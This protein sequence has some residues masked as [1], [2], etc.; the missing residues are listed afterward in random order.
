MI[1]N[2]FVLCNLPGFANNTAAR[3]GGVA[4]GQLYVN[5]GLSSGEFILCQA[6]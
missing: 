6:H 4:V 3:T 2:P 1:E 5:T